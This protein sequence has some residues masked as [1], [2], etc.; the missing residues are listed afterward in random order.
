MP[1]SI[2]Y[3][4]T[5]MFKW[6]TIATL[7]G[8]GGGLSAVLLR[9]A[10]DYVTQLS[11]YVPIWLAP[12]I[13][14]ILVVL[15][16]LWDTTASG[17]GTDRYMCA[18]NEEKGYLKFRSSISKLIASALTIGF[19]GSGGVEGPMLIIGG[20]AGSTLSRIP[21]LNR[22]LDKDDYRIL[23]ICGAAG[24]IGAIFR[25]PLGGGIFVVELLYRSSLH[26]FELFPAILS[27]TMGFVVFSMLA[28]GN[29]I[30]MIPDYL[31]NVFNVP[32][33][34]L[35]GVLGGIM[36]LIFMAV[37]SKTK[38]TFDQM[39]FKRFHPIAGGL[40]TGVILIYLPRVGGAGTSMIQ[41]MIDSPQSY[42]LLLLLFVGKMLATSFTV[43]SGGSAGL[44]IPALFIGAIAG[45]IS[46][47]LLSVVDPGLSASLVISGMAASLASIANV[48][49]AAAIMLV[50]MV[51]LRLGVP[52]TLGS[53]MGYAIG[54]SRTI[55]GTTC[56][57]QD[58]F[59]EAKKFR[60]S[61][62]KLDG[63]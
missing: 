12:V 18:V 4:S 62:R 42:H 36:S 23:T 58:D 3:V 31:P 16:Y 7:V 34:I 28:N 41:E 63:H 32:T 27:S 2:K 49:I 21:I 60:K 30:F 24:A 11:T 43:G 25:S 13:G 6:L 53:I 10:I 1:K 48:P 29:P 57:Y 47:N 45:S 17:F 51:G 14:G 40:L 26:Y 35:A 19:Q 39:S 44:V 52:A 38:A 46:N 8:I 54:H 5:Y 33:F 61:D 59:E 37:F 20:S 55:Y 56:S 15:V 50:E 22:F 9:M